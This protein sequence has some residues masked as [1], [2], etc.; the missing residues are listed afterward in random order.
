MDLAVFMVVGYLATV[1]IEGCILWFG[2]S[3]QHSKRTRLLAAFW[4]TACTY[5]MVVLVLPV[6]ELSQSRWVYL[7]VAE[8]F[9]IIG[10]CLLFRAAFPKEPAGSSLRDTAVVA[11]A[12]LASFLLGELWWQS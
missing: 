11:V 3:S 4:L 7:L 6:L 12:N 2:L 1:S 5:P 10:E 8:S 9:A